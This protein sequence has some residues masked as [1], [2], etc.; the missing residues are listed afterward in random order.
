MKE[1]IE[2][3]LVYTTNWAARRGG[4]Q[5]QNFADIHCQNN[6]RPFQ[7]YLKIIQKHRKEGLTTIRE[8]FK[9]FLE[10]FKY[11]AKELTFQEKFN[12]SPREVESIVE[13]P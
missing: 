6:C 11:I 7:S 12:N 8:V 2:F 13:Y 3:I 10:T 5:I 4:D 9:P 1:F